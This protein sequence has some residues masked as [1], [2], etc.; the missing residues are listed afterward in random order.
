MTT[1]TTTHTHTEPDPPHSRLGA[2]S[3][4]FSA[5]SNPAYRL[6][7]LEYALNKVGCK[8]LVTSPALKSSRQSPGRPSRPAR[9]G[10]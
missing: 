2:I 3:N 5:F 9:R 6:A 7:E 1:D 4:T 8:A 10:A